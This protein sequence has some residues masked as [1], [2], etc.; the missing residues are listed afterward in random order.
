MYVNNNAYIRETINRLVE[1]QISNLYE[2]IPVQITEYNDNLTVNCKSLVDKR[3]FNDISVFRPI[4]YMIK[5]E[6]IKYG[7][8]IGTKY[9][10]NELYTEGKI[11]STIESAL[12]NFGIIIP[13]LD[14]DILQMYQDN[15]E[16][17]I[18]LFNKDNTNKLTM[19]DKDILINSND[20][21]K[22]TMNDK[23]IIVNSNDKNQLTINDQS[24][25]MNSNNS[26]QITMDNQSITIDG[27]SIVLNGK[28]P[29]DIKTSS[30]SL[31]ELLNEILNMLM[32]MNLDTVAGNGA[33]LASPTLAST[34][35]QIQAKLSLLLK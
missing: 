5:P 34:L 1:D 28:Q 27:S 25:N 35:P 16:F 11:S 19:N 3:I 30:T 15:K 33:P 26:N 14:K 2:N 6:N 29:L 13:L 24:I 12:T 9:F 31:K 20:K 23:D 32:K 17:D 8:L 10:F 18:S 22:I 21:N 4:G 7:L